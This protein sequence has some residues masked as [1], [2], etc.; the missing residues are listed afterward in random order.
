M[1]HLAIGAFAISVALLSVEA[2]AAQDDDDA[3]WGEP[4]AKPAKKKKGGEA[5]AAA[6]AS[7]PVAAELPL[8][9][10]PDEGV[11]REAGHEA[12]PP[13]DKTAGSEKPPE[14][15]EEEVPAIAEQAEQLPAPQRP[16]VYGKRSGW[17][18]TPYGYARFDGIE[19]NTQSFEDGIQPNL[20]QRAGTY[21]GDHRRTIFTARDS[22]LGVFIGAPDYRGMRTMGQVEFDFYGIIPSDAR[23]HDSIVFGTPRIRLAYLKLETPVID[24]IAGQ[25]YDLFGWN[26]YFYPATVA[27]LGVPAQIYHR[28][29]QLRLEK[30]FGSAVEITIAAAAV[31]PGQRDSGYP[32][33]QAGIKVAVPGWSGAA[34]PGFGRPSLMPLSFGFSGIYRLF[35]LPAFRSEP[36]SSAVR[37]HGYGAAVSALIPI[38]PVR[39]IKS[40]AN[41]LTVTGEFSIGTGLADMYTFMDGGSRMPLLPNPGQNQPAIQY[42]VNIDPGLVT[43]NRDLKVRSINWTAFVAGVQYYLPIDKGRIWVAGIYSRIWSNNIKD[44]TPAPSWGGIFTKMEYFDANVSIDITPAVVLGLSFQSV[45]QT[46]GDEAPRTPIFGAIAQDPHVPLSIDGTGG[47]A[48]HARND[49]LQLSMSLFF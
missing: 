18:I 13:A 7:E 40:R 15:Q 47:Q 27:Y 17:N 3:A 11:P 44:L 43:F 10:P 34:T 48:A 38:I 21:R 45:K 14:A 2:R 9:A 16:P 29:P 20:I 32:E 25:Y 39:T 31:R 49:R 28:N 46:F 30:K 33:G 12:A 37:T 1:R 36:G 22:R 19:D 6:P 35:E 42:P 26:S 24:I 41:A 23:R 5:K 4:A 8:P